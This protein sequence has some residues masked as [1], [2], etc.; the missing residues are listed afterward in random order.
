MPK[1][2]KT[3]GIA[4]ILDIP[5]AGIY[6]I[7]C[8]VDTGA[9]NCSIDC[10]Y[11]GI[12]SIDNESYLEY[13]LLGDEYTQKSSRKQLTKN[14]IQK[15]VKSSNGVSEYRYQVELEVVI[16]ENKYKAIFNLSKRHNMKYPILLGRKLLSKN[17]LVDVSRKNI[18]I[19]KTKK[20]LS[21]Y[22]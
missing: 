6:K 13:T 4:D 17:F 8:K 11:F 15:K 14:F 20:H 22:L 16:F 7:P 2:K 19:G 9:Y 18:S 12:V 1:T 3:I 21:Y 5:S 10:S